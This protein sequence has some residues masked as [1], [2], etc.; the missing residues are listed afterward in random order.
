MRSETDGVSS[1]S[2]K[3]IYIIHMTLTKQKW[4]F[5]SCCFA[6]KIGVMSP[7]GTVGGESEVQVH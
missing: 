1:H 6:G 4:L 5:R 7:R 2:E 3:V